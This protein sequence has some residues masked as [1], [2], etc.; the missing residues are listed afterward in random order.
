MIARSCSIASLFFLE[1]LPVSGKK[2]IPRRWA[3]QK[4]E[5]VSAARVQNEIREFLSIFDN[6]YPER[7][8]VLVKL[9]ISNPPAYLIQ[10]M[11]RS[12]P[13]SRRRW[14]RAIFNSP[15]GMPRSMPACA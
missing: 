8:S 9:R 5:A 1:N 12:M 4:G 10:D 13:G 2:Q 7:G 15:R 11:T 6:K 3:S 14:S